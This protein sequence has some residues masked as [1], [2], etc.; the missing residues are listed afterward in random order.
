MCNISNQYLGC[1][2]DSTTDRA[3]SGSHYITNN[4]TVA[5]CYTFCAA[6]SDYTYFGVEDGKQWYVIQT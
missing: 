6:D 5:N 3:L 2:T 1:Y 4:L